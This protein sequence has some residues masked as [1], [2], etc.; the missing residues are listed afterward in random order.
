VFHGEPSDGSPDVDA[1]LR[2]G[3]RVLANLAAGKPALTNASGFLP[4]LVEVENERCIGVRL[5]LP[6]SKRAPAGSPLVLFAVGSPTW[7]GAWSRPNDVRTMPAGFLTRALLA[8]GFDR[9]G[10]FACAVLAADGDQQDPVAAVGKVLAVL[11]ALAPVDPGRVVLVGERESAATLLASARQPFLSKPRA[12][13]CVAGGAL[14]PSEVGFLEH[15]A[16][17][18]VP[19]RG[20]LSE[21]NMRRLVKFAA[22]AGHAERVRLL[23]P[24]HA[25]SWALPWALPAIESYCRDVLR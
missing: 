14:S 25:W 1:D 4:L 11:A 17:L 3:E 16:I 18:L 15:T 22:D 7:D 24:T 10:E 5:R 20:H 13:V 19:A 6:V 12:V 21:E 9:D 23:E 2:H 8:S